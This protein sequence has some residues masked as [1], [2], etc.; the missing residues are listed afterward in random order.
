MG[1]PGASVI[2]EGA[3]RPGGISMF[4]PTQI[5]AGLTGNGRRFDQS[6][7]MVA[8]AG[9]EFCITN[10][11]LTPW[12]SIYIPN[13]MLSGAGSDAETPVASMYGFVQV[14]LHK[15]ERF[16]WVFGQFHEMVQQTPTSFESA[17][18]KKATG[19]KLVS[20]IRRLLAVPG[21]VEPAPGRHEV[22][23]EQIIRSSMDFFDQHDGEYLS[24]K[25]LAAAAQVSERTLREAF[26]QYFGVAPV[27]Y[28]N[29]RTLHRVRM[30]LKAADPEV[31]TVTDIL[32]RF[33]IWELGCFAQ[34]YRL[35]F[36][37]LPSQTLRR[38]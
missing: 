23:R 35:L 6:S 34:N 4:L 33:G 11:G 1:L 28:L 15:V 16:R 31:T 22:P 14:P 17:A 32:M 26:Q 10:N 25:Q 9:D 12:V 7:V 3:V 27:R 5:S 37:E 19:Q 18:A 29:Q 36:E 20:E 21:G 8:Q 24:V 2:G 13:E 38:S 30:A